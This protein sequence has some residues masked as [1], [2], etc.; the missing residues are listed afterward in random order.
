V[1]A[2]GASGVGGAG[3]AGG[4]GGS[5]TAGATNGG[6]GGGAGMGQASKCGN[7]VPELG[8]DCDDGGTLPGDG[9]SPTCKLESGWSC[10]GDEPSSCSPTYPSCAGMSGTECFGE[11]CCESLGI[12]YGTFTQ[13]DSSEGTFESTVAGFKLDRFEVTVARF[14]AFF[15]AYGDWAPAN[16]TAGAG[17]HPKVANSGWSTDWELPASPSELA[18]ALDCDSASQSWVST[19]GNDTLPMNCIDWFTAFA[20][21]IWDGGRLP[22]EAEWEITARWGGYEQPYPWGESPALTN[23]QDYTAEYAVYNCLGDGSA[24]GVCSTVDILSVGSKPDG[25]SWAGVDDLLGS[26]SEWMLDWYAPYPTGPRMDYANV[27][28]SGVQRTVRGGSWADD[29][30]YQSTVLRMQYEPTTTYAQ[31]GFRCARS[32]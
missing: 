23:E 29:A 2:G 13:G 6:S 26:V 18:S 25:A 24:G 27:A 15:A 12:D 11:D 32:R 8:E 19:A 16:P 9:C 20:F 22:T 1:T 4:A 28:G 14:R 31:I 21:C 10:T 17:A 5:V 7:D 30:D 3:G